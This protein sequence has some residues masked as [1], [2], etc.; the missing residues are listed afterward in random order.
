MTDNQSGLL[1]PKSAGEPRWVEDVL[2]FWFHEIAPRAWFVRDAVVDTEIGLRFAD[3]HTTLAGGSIHQ[4]TRESRIELARVI[5]LDQFPR[6]IF[7]GTPA[8]FATDAQA[9]ATARAAV[10]AGLDQAVDGN[11]RLFFY[12][13]F[14]HSEVAADQQRCVELISAI[15]D[16][17]YTR[18]AQAHKDII[19][20]FG[21]FPHRNQMLGRVSTPE[22]IAFLTQPG[23][24]F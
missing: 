9:L 20:R 14:E 5:V 7:R 2:R 15:G 16:A 6:N 13:P 11:G 19:D 22:E 24:S 23:S 18:F 12:L 10:A 4:V 17:E 3:L 8:A 21:R 1:L